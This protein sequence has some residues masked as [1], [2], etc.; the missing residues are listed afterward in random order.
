M[1]K[2]KKRRSA[3]Q[4]AR[5]PSVGEVVLATHLRACKIGFEQE[6]KFHPERKWRADFLIKGSKIL[7]EVEGG[8]WSGGR[9]TRGKGYLGDMEKYNS[10]AMMGFTVLR[11]DTQQVKSG[12]AI[13]Q[14]ENLVR[15]GL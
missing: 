8:I 13:K 7:I 11:F 15:G 9:H 14:I 2:N 1:K 10:A 12:L 3:K 5:Q 4:V 6:Y